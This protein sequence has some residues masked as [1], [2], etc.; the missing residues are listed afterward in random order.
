MKVR[1]KC[2]GWVLMGF[3][4][5]GC[6]GDLDFTVR[7]DAIDALRTDDRVLADSTAIGSVAGIEDTAEGDYR[8]AVR[9]ERRHADTLGRASVFYIDAD[10]QK[11]GRKAL[12]VLAAPV[13]SGLIGDG[14]TV[15]G[16]A[17]WSALLQR[18]T[19][20]MENAA[21]GITDEIDRYWQELQD[22]PTREQA[23]RLEAELDRILAELKRLNAAAQHRLKTEILPRLREQLDELR[24]KLTAPDHD[25]QLDRLEDK[26]DRIDREMR[27]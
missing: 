13:A 18:L 7:F 4:L 25:V 2:W 19:R 26:F 9:I 14:E 12:M 17:K 27:V 8:V 1:L 22:L 24:H 21:A 10:P 6:G 5:A 23:R 3:L 16:T 11:P 20:R 15:E